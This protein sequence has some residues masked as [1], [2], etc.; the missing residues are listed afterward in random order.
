[1]TFN[2]SNEL[3][4]YLK[5]QEDLYC[6]ALEL[7]VTVSA[8]WIVCSMKCSLPEAKE[9][10]YLSLKNKTYSLPH[11]AFVNTDLF[12]INEFC[13]KYFNIRYEN[14][15]ACIDLEPD[16]CMGD[17]ETNLNDIIRDLKEKRINDIFVDINISGECEGK[18]IY[19]DRKIVYLSPDEVAVREMASTD[20]LIAELKR[21]GCDVIKT[22][23]LIKE[24]RESQVKAAKCIGFIAGMVSQIWVINDILGKLIED[25]DGEPYKVENGKLVI[26]NKEIKR[27]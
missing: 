3:K 11:T 27:G 16:R 19:E 17:V 15:R 2:N 7:F 13:G 1:M 22:D 20:E 21:R 14:E 6:P 23:D 25:Y 26:K 12:E 24:L 9:S 8:N 5:C 10:V 18:Y 4:E